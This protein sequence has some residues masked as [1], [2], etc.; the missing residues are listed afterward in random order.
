MNKKE[1]I[2]DGNIDVIPDLIPHK[3]LFATFNE[4]VNWLKTTLITK[5]GFKQSF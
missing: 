1:K 2:Y 3:H 5:N 4:C